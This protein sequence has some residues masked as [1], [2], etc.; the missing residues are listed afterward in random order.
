[1]GWLSSFVFAQFDISEGVT[2]SV[3]FPALGIT[4]VANLAVFV[5]SLIRGRLDLEIGARDVLDIVVSPKMLINNKM[6]ISLRH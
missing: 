6:L 1:M 5:T 3:D 4:C 2:G